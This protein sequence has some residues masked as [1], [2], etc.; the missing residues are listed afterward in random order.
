MVLHFSLNFLVPTGSMPYLPSEVLHNVDREV[1]ARFKG[2]VLR[3]EETQYSV[4]KQKCL[5]E[6][7]I[8][9]EPLC[10]LLQLR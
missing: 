7:G 4:L 10:S 9:R 1:N 2:E 3:L 8:N 5:F 6:F